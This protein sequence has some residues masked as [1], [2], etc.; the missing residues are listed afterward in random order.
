[1]GGPLRT[2]QSVLKICVWPR[3]FPRVSLLWTEEWLFFNKNQ[4]VCRIST[5]DGFKHVCEL[6]DIPGF[7]RG[8]LNPSPLKM[9]WAQWHWVTLRLGYK[10]CSSLALCQD[11]CSSNPAPVL[12]K[13]R[14]HGEDYRCSNPQLLSSR[15]QT[16]FEMTPAPT[17][18]ACSLLR[19]SKWQ[20]PFE[21]RKQ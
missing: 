4:R 8:S 2:R 11:S 3:T 6:F 19:D 9:G 12:R 16:A 17:P 20:P 18:G 1:M 21:P 10:R 5:Y 14:D 7:K 15:E 13:P